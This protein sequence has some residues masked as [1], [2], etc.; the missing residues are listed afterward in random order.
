MSF[1][2][3]TVPRDTLLYHGNRRPDGPEGLDWLSFEISHAEIF[4][5]GTRKNGHG[6]LHVYRTT[7]ALRLLYVDGTSGGTTNMGTLDSQ[8]YILRR[9]PTLKSQGSRQQPVLSWSEKVDEKDLATDLCQVAKEWHLE[10]I[11]RMEAGFEIIKCNFSDGLEPVHALRRPHGFSMGLSTVKSF[12][13]LRG[14]TGQYHGLGS[15]QL[16]IDYSSMVSAYFFPINLTN[17][18]TQRPD[19]PRLVSADGTELT[20]IY[21]Y[22]GN[23]LTQRAD[24]SP[25]VNWRDISDLIVERYADRIQFIAEEITSV[26]TLEQLIN[27]LLTVFIDYTDDEPDIPAAISRCKDLYLYSGPLTTDADSLIQSAFRAVTTDV[28]ESLFEIRQLAQLD[29]SDGEYVARAQ[30]IAQPL[31]GR[32]RWTRFKRCPPCRLDQVCAI[33]M[34]PLGTV[35]EYEKPQCSSSR[36]KKDPDAISYWGLDENE[37]R[38]KSKKR[39]ESGSTRSVQVL[40]TAQPEQEDPVRSSETLEH[41]REL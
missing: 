17:P 19:L 30:D 14:I 29:V 13:F 37:T 27:F 3:A 36:M 12:E 31:M 28:C 38:K 40:N 5:Q 4:S 16:T 32:L 11:V 10:G 34:W 35:E 15:S 9:S 8:D 21:Q 22:L 41:M 7:R 39:T 2:R 24:D 23:V 33:P 18:N 25:A 26:R 20:A 6:Y 1:F